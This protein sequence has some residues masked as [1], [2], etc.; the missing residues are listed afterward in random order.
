[1]K[2][3]AFLGTG[4]KFCWKWEAPQTHTQKNCDTQHN[5]ERWTDPLAKPVTAGAR[6]E[7]GQMCTTE[8]RCRWSKT[9]ER[10]KK[11]GDDDNWHSCRDFTVMSRSSLGTSE[12]SHSVKAF[13]KGLL[14]EQPLGLGEPMRRTCTEMHH[15]TQRD[16][17]ELAM[18]QVQHLYTR[19]KKKKKRCCNSNIVFYEL[20]VDQYTCHKCVC[21]T[22][23]LHMKYNLSSQPTPSTSRS[24][25]DV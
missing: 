9:H 16:D 15:C 25:S 12:I 5:Q 19:K 6:L 17:A 3:I 7:R 8:E 20:E 24:Y 21:E 1:M 18:P 4:T 2:S 14:I 10:R 13:E 22:Q 23:P 11:K